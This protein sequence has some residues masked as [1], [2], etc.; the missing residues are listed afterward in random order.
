MG[1]TSRVTFI[2]L[3]NHERNEWHKIVWRS[4]LFLI[5]SWARKYKAWT[6]NCVFSLFLSSMGENVNYGTWKNFFL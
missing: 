4:L 2:F 6:Q 1:E 3:C 5:M